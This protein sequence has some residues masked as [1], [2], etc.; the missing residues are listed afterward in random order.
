[1]RRAALLFMV[2]LALAPLALTACNR[3]RT[4]ETTTV[5]TKDG[6]TTTTVT[7]RKVGAHDDDKTA[8]GL[9]IDTDKFKANIE[10]PGLSL[11]GD[12]MD[13]DGMKLYPGSTV[14]GMHVKASDH[15]GDSRGTVTMDFTSPAA[16]AAVADHMKA[17]AEKAGFTVVG[18]SAAGLTGT[19]VEDK[20][21]N[22]F[23]ITLNPNGDAT[24]GQLVMTGSKEKLGW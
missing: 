8:A 18:A 1:M 11:G 13:M 15:N 9:D 2:P 23:T 10:I 12:H 22:H 3:H 4:E 14:K 19:K 24:V 5:V 16:P 17:Q 7:T 20:D 21:T 6:V